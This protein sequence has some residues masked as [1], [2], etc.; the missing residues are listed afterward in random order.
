MLTL[1]LNQQLGVPTGSD[2]QKVVDKGYMAKPARSSL[3]GCY[4]VEGAIASKLVI[5]SSQ[6]QYNHKTI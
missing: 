3:A 2:K 1:S 6:K 5:L 4:M